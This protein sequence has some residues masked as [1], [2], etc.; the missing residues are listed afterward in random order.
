MKIPSKGN[1]VEIAPGVRF[2]ERNHSRPETTYYLETLTEPMEGEITIQGKTYK[3][4]SWKA[5]N[6]E[7]GHVIDY[8][9][10]CCLLHYAPMLFQSFED[11]E[12]FWNRPMDVMEGQA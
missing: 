11:S 8:G 5:R 3:Q 6:L 1:T 12:E 10:T 4:Y 2:V 7:T 9:I